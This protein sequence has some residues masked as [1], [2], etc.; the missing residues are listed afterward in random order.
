M[1]LLLHMLPYDLHRRPG[2]TGGPGAVS[3]S[4]F[5]EFF[6]VSE[7]AMRSKHDRLRI[8]GALGALAL[9]VGA[10][11][12]LGAPGAAA[13]G[14]D[15]ALIGPNQVFQGQVN[16]VTEDAVIKVGCFGPVTPA[17]TGHPI[18]GQ[19]VDVRYTPDVTSKDGTGF[20]GSA[21]DHVIVGFDS[22]PSTGQVVSISAY[23]TKVVI[24]AS[25]N[26]PCF[27]TGTVQFAPSPT[28]ATAR[29]A[30]VPVTYASIG[31]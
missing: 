18:A 22:G 5:S 25:L 7:A 8:Y 11:G 27:G 14:P 17:S 2:T 13:A 19:T 12:V 30:S 1:L 29:T 21:A 4:E 16:T 10:A 31:D 24:P 23:D 26:L 15:V 3:E 28:S 20:T 6:G 9:G